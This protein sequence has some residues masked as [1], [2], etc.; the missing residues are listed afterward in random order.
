MTWTTANNEAFAS[1]L[2]AW[3]RDF[4]SLYERSKKLLAKAT[5]N[6]ILNSPQFTD[7]PTMTKDDMIAM[8]GLITQVDNIVE[9]L[10]LTQ[11][12]YKTDIF[13]ALRTSTL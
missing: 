7:T 13:R 10:P 9:N 4:Y 8:A 12:D 5:A 11:K 2:Q 1:D 3:T 6:D